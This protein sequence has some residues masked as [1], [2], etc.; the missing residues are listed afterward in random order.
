MSTEREVMDIVLR[1][2]RTRELA[3]RAVREHPNDIKAL[4]GAGVGF[5]LSGDYESAFTQFERAAALQP[6]NHFV[7]FELGNVH[8]FLGRP[9]EAAACYARVVQVSPGY[10]KARHALIQVEKQTAEHNSIQELQ[11]A[12][13]GRD[14]DGWRT[15]HIGH[16]L[17]KTHEDLGDVSTSFQ[18][19]HRAKKRRR[20]MHPYFPADREKLTAAAMA[21]TASVPESVVGCASS[22]PIFVCGMPRTGTTLVDRIL[23]SHPD[24]T[25]AGEIGN[26]FQLFKRLGSNT[27]R[28][29]LEPE[30]LT[31]G[32]AIDYARLG[33]LYIDSTRPISGKTPRFI[34]KA[35]S[36]YLLAGVIL[37]ALPNARVICVRRHPL[38]T[39][40]S[41][42][43]QIF[44]LDDRYYDYVYDLGAAAHQYVQFDAIVKHWRHTLPAHQF[45]EL[46][47][48]DLVARQEEQTRAL[49]AFCGLGWDARCLDF[50]KNASAVAT[51][52]AAQV[53]QAMYS[54][55]SGRWVKYGEL[56][57]P[58]KAVLER[59]GLI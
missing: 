1:F 58:A 6:N 38:D 23:S 50:H 18:W 8:E 2:T 27:S 45:L 11:A 44:P 7:L 51:P 54:S 36:N 12:F 28:I 47:Y 56:L 55:A 37:K 15:L 17:A 19:L 10:Y 9:T 16:A 43:K 42:Y 39:V 35:P 25:S 33:K 22:E 41:N 46:G 32:G 59:S 34:D 14:E 4:F 53:R 48:E 57:D 31:G 21:S 52:S 26:F 13:A 24:V 30:T 3:A 40:L 20:E 49:L 5:R 29:T